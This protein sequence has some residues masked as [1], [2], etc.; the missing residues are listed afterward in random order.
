MTENEDFL[1][2]HR[3]RIKERFV[4]TDAGTWADYE[5]LELLLTYAIPRVDVKPLAKSLILHFGSLGE[6]LTASVDELMKIKGIKENTAILIKTVFYMQTR[7]LKKDMQSKTKLSSW[8]SIENYCYALLGR[9]KKEYVYLILLDASCCV[10]DAVQLQKGT[11]DQASVYIREVV[12]VLIKNHAMSFIMVHNHPSGDTRP[13]P[14][15]IRLTHLI[16]DT[17]RKLNI[18]M[19]DHF[20]VSPKGINSFK[21]MDLMKKYDDNK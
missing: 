18:N 5:L 19:Q 20:I 1:K 7:L 9:E 14:D 3:Q 12:E 13:S 11:V 17:T 15:D 2:G 6:V 10:I 4:K 16:Q 21:L 8:E